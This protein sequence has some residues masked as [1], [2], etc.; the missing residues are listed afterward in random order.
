MTRA[1]VLRLLIGVFLLLAISS[2]GTFLD[3]ETWPTAPLP[4]APPGTLAPRWEAFTR[5][6]PDSITFEAIDGDGD[7]I[8]GVEADLSDLPPGHNAVFTT[9]IVP[10]SPYRR[11][12]T[13]RWT[14]TAGDTGLYRV[15]FTAVNEMRGAPDTT[16]LY[17]N[18]HVADLPPVITVP[19]TVQVLVGGPWDITVSADDPEGD[20][21]FLF[22]PTDPIGSSTQQALNL[23]AW[24]PTLAG[25]HATGVLRIRANQPGYFEIRFTAVNAMHGFGSLAVRALVVE[26]GP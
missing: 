4:N 22:V 6:Q 8:A 11:R 2:C 23:L 3:P 18:D 20:P 10:G 7:P 16:I 19:D 12:C 15:V 1:L 5:L 26:A 14:A 13:L 25:S 17:T 9:R 21:I 24:T